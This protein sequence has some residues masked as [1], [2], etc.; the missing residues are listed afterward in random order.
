MTDCRLFLP[1]DVNLY[2]VYVNSFKGFVFN[3]EDENWKSCFKIVFNT[4]YRHYKTQTI[5]Y[6]KIAP[7]PW[8]YIVSVTYCVALLTTVLAAWPLRELQDFWGVLYS[9][10]QPWK[11]AECVHVYVWGLGGAPQLPNYSPSPRIW[12]KVIVPG[13]PQVKAFLL[14]LPFNSPHRILFLI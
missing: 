6:N 7:E 3:I 8:R 9:W 1:F 4:L 13:R 14:H 5:F 11:C 2:S 12:N 10:T